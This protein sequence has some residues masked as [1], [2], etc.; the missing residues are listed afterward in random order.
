MVMLTCC[1]STREKIAHDLKVTL[2]FLKLYG[3]WQ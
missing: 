2:I 3:K 1:D